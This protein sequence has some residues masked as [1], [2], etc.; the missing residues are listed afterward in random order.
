MKRLTTFQAIRQVLLYFLPFYF[1]PLMSE[2]FQLFMLVCGIPAYCVLFL[3]L[4]VERGN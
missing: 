1:L 3:M 2:E 4:F